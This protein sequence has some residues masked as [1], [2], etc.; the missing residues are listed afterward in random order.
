MPV[1]IFSAVLAIG[2]LATPA[3]STLMGT[4]NINII[5]SPHDLSQ[6]GMVDNSN[7]SYLLE[8]SLTAAEITSTFY[9]DLLFDH[10]NI[11]GTTLSYGATYDLTDSIPRILGAGIPEK[12]DSPTIT[13]HLFHFDPDRDG[14]SSI[15]AS[16]SFDNEKILAVIFTSSFLDNSDSLFGISG[17]TYPFGYSNRGFETDDFSDVIGIGSDGMSFELKCMLPPTALMRFE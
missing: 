9:V 6:G 13:S 3:L 2:F 4:S 14:V 1:F 10:P 7:L 15:T 11:G 12:V 17:I 16:G 5:G 8:K